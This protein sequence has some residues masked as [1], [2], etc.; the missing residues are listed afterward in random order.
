VTTKVVDC[1]G[2][3]WVP[4]IFHPSYIVRSISGAELAHDGRQD[5]KTTEAAVR[6]TLRGTKHRNITCPSNAHADERTGLARVVP[7]VLH[8]P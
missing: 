1:D 3:R 5:K 8:D 7:S 4:I 2:C 6:A